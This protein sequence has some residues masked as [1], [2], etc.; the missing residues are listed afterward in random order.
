MEKTI[1]L[2]KLVDGDYRRIWYNKSEQHV[3]ESHAKALR[4][5]DFNGFGDRD[6]T[7]FGA[8]DL[9][10]YIEY[11]EDQGIG[12]NTLN[13][14]N[15]NVSSIF[16]YAKDILKIIPDKPT[17]PS[18]HVTTGRPR[19]MS[20][21]EMEQ[22]LSYKWDTHAWWMEHMIII[23]MHTGMR[24]GE[25]LSIKPH[26]L[27]RENG[28]EYVDLDHTKNGTVRR[29]A[30]SDEACKALKALSFQPSRHHV[31]TTFYRQWDKARRKIAPNDSY[32][33]FHAIRHT[34]ATK[35]ATEQNRNALVIQSIMGHKS[36]ETTSRYVHL[37]Q[38]TQ[39]DYVSQLWKPRG[40]T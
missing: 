39:H 34:V 7:S 11:L 32:F 28:R 3:K 21:D 18:R 30:M 23:A 31:R 15:S 35:L 40:A 33:V 38:E 12:D 19:Y 13:H 26:M 36:L 14:Y 9:F 20:N 22:L 2:R 25:I 8:P 17:I 24:R 29:V 16:K 37:N 27:R 10:D 5:C 4:F 1:K 6:I